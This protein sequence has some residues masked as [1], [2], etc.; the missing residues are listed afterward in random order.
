[1]VCEQLAM[2]W[3]ATEI[4]LLSSPGNGVSFLFQSSIKYQAVRNVQFWKM[5]SLSYGVG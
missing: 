5:R 1:M 2:W 3:A 4:I